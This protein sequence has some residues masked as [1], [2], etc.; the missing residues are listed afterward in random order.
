MAD[1]P[2]TEHEQA[3]VRLIIGILIVLYFLPDIA[4]PGG[5]QVLF[6]ES[7]YV[8]IGALIF[9]FILYS[10]AASPPRRV[11]ALLTDLSTL[12][13]YMAFLGERAAPLSWS[14]S[15]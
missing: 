1:R 6:V 4:K 15:G 13:W 9:L 8:A 12:T 2:D 11:I 3:I 14:T 10:P 7:A 5:T